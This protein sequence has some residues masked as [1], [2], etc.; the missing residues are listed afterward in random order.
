MEIVVGIAVL[1]LKKMEKFH[2][3]RLESED[4]RENNNDE[5]EILCKRV[6]DFVAKNGKYFVKFGEDSDQGVILGFYSWC[7]QKT[8]TNAYSED[9]CWHG[10]RLQTLV[11]CLKNILSEKGLETLIAAIKENC[12]FVN[13]DT[14]IAELIEIIIDIAQKAIDTKSAMVIVPLCE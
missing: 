4:S 13:D 3:L 10:E 8:G 7:R 11:D 1:D 12:F 9:H 5:S 2:S 14:E 6:Y